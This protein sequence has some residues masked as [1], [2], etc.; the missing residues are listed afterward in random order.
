MIATTK[1]SVLLTGSAGAVVVGVGP[2]LH[3]DMTLVALVAAGAGAV[4]SGIWHLVHSRAVD[5]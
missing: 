2:S 3:S 5:R 4:A 1:L